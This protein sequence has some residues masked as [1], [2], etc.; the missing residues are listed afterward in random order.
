M[1]WLE[2]AV[3]VPAI[4]SG[5]MLI[6]DKFKVPGVDKHK[7]VVASIPEGLQLAELAAGKDLLQDEAIAS[8]INNY[9]VAEAAAMKAKDTLKA[10]ILAKKPAA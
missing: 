3:K 1:N 5:A 4:I 7:A 2:F 6:A 10:G 9:I 8:L